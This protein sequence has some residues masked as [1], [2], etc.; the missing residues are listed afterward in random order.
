MYSRHA[1]RDRLCTHYMRFLADMK[2]QGKTIGSIAIVNENTDYGTSVG[3]AIVAEAKTPMF[4]SQS[5]FP[6]APAPPTS[7]RKSS[8][9][10]KRS[11]TSSSSS[12][13]RGFDP[14]HEDDEESRLQ[15][16]D[17]AGRRQRLFRSFVIPAVND[18][19]QGAMNRSAWAIGK[20]GSTTDKINE[21][22]KA[23]T[24]RNLDDT[25]ARNMQGFSR[26]RRGDQ[27]R[28]LD[29]SEK[30]RDALTKTISSPT[31]S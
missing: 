21:M 5:V 6:I 3:D 19:A 25:S 22:Y 15:A 8:S 30:M 26:A 9:S 23:K 14:L 7:P 12:A 1:D 20:P 18:I 4:R 28:R 27:S 16:A 24:G 11:P 10:S 29:R 31:S 13:Y 2:K 17:G